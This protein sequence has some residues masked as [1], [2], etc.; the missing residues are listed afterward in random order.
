MIKK[1]INLT[2]KEKHLFIF[3]DW[4]NV[5]PF[6]SEVRSY[7]AYKLLFTAESLPLPVLITD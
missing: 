5:N 2:F 6:T 7:T 3:L 1:L 4:F